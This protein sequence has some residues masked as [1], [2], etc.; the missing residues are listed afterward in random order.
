MPLAPQ[1]DQALDAFDYAGWRARQAAAR[2]E[3]RVV[4]IGL[5][6]LVQGSAAADR[7]GTRNYGAINGIIAAPLTI[8]TAFG[9]SL[10]PLLAVATGSYSSMALM[11]VGLALVALIFARFS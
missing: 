6:T 10:G 7:W 1:L 8:V 11:A 3:G 2:A 4:G 5:S 9:P